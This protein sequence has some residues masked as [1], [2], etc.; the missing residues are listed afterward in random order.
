MHPQRALALI[1]KNLLKAEASIR[2]RPNEGALCQISPLCPFRPGQKLKKPFWGYLSESLVFF[3]PV[4]ARAP[5]IPKQTMKKAM[6][7][8]MPRTG[9]PTGQKN[10]GV[11]KAS[12]HLGSKAPQRFLGEHDFWEHF[13]LLVFGIQLLSTPRSHNGPLG[14]NRFPGP[15]KFLANLPVVND[16]N[17]RAL[18]ARHRNFKPPKRPPNLKSISPTIQSFE[19][20]S[21]GKLH[22]AGQRQRGL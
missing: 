17:E 7:G 2:K 15:K 18:G 16:A 8:T 3:G 22:G 1:L 4:L 12:H 19:R 11:P 13:E 10:P 21:E 5:I 14:Q 6:L 9:P 20:G